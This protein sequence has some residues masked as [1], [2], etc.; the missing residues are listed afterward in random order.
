MGRVT[1]AYVTQHGLTVK[2]GLF[3]GMT[4]PSEA[5]GHAG[6]LPAKLLGCYEMELSP[7][8][9]QL[10]SDVFVDIGSGDG[11]YCV[12][13]ARLFAG[14]RVIG[15]ETQLAERRV[16]ER[17]A[18]LN[19]VDVEY[20]ATAD[21]AALDALPA[22]RLAILCDIEGAEFELLDPIAAPRLREAAMIVEV[23]PATRANLVETMVERF[24]PT[25]AH[26]LVDGRPRD[27][28]AYPELAG[29]DSLAANISVSEGRQKHGQWLVLTPSLRRRAAG[30]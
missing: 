26:Q 8:L 24:A 28:S 19:G 2:R 1:K 30:A 13:L 5:V 15:F 9:S 22:G 14:V 3:A 23:H 29:W 17:L 20:R 11:W 10:E 7:H 27:P 16:A 6:M 4:Y 18:Q 21:H 25:H 12:G